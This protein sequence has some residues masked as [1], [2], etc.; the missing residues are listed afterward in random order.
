MLVAAGYRSLR[1]RS[2]ADGCCIVGSQGL[3]RKAGKTEVCGTH[4]RNRRN[5]TPLAQQNRRMH[6]AN[7]EGYEG[8]MIARDANEV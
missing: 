8:M 1:P 6:K 3:G 4:L 2:D 7:G 5:Y